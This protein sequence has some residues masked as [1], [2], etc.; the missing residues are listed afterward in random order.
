MTPCDDEQGPDAHPRVGALLASLAQQ[1]DGLRTRYV[2]REANRACGTCKNDGGE[3][4]PK[5]ILVQTLLSLL[6]FQLTQ[7][8]RLRPCAYAGDDM[9]LADGV[10]E[11]QN[12]FR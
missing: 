6:P 3:P 4:A 2:L 9:F 10:S 5:T 11:F 8:A 7:M 12:S 1:C